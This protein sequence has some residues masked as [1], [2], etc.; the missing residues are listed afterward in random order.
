MDDAC[1][2]TV[3]AVNR[4]L[5][6]P[7]VLDLDLRSFG[8]LTP[9]MHSVLHHDDMK[10]ENTESAPDV[11]KP[12]TLPCPKPGEPIVL[13]AASWNVIRFTKG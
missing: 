9:A 7:M 6:E 12:V 4:D 1:N 11:V 10:V 3:F 8:D 2:V 13:P 5:T